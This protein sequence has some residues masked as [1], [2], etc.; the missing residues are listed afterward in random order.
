[1]QAPE[2]PRRE[3]VEERHGVEL[4]DPYRWLEAD[5]DDAPAVADWTARQN[6]YAAAVLDTPE[7]VAIEPRFAE[8]ARV[9]EYGPLSLAGGRSFQ[10][11]T[12]PDDEQAALYVRDGPDGDR[13]L[14]V[15]PGG[16]RGVVSLDWFVPSPDG[17]RAAYGVAEGGDEQYDVRVVD[18]DDGAVAEA[19]PDAGRLYADGLA[20]DADG[21]GFYY[22]T[23]GADGGDQLDK[24]VRYHA[25]GSDHRDD[26]LVAG[27]FGRQVWPGLETEGDVLVVEYQE[28]WDRS[29]VRAL[30]ADPGSATA[31]ELSLS[32]VVVDVDATVH[33]HLS[34]DR[35]FLVTDHGAP[36]SRVLACSVEEALD[37]PLALD[38]LD[39]PV[40][41]RE[42]VLRDVAVADDRL[43]AHYHDDAHSRVVSLDVADGDEE[44]DGTGDDR[45]AGG[46]DDRARSAAGPPAEVELDVPPYASVEALRADDGA[47]VCTVESFERPTRVCRADPR[48]GEVATIDEP[49]VPV[50]LDLVVDQEWFES[51]D[52]TSVPAFVVR[53]A[54]VERDGDR[55]TVLAGYGGFRVNSTPGFD[56]FRAPF[57]AAGGVYVLATLRG[58]AEFGEAWHDAGRREHKQRVFDDAVAVAEGLIDRGYTRPARLGIAGGSNGGLLVATLLT[59]R[60]ALFGAALCRV[61]LTDMLRFH[62]FLLGE[63]WTTEYGNP[64]DPA[65][66]EYLRAYSPYHNVEAAAYPPTLVTTA[67]GDTRVHPSHARKFVARLQ[68]ATTGS[69]PVVLRTREETG[70]GVGKPTSML[71]EENAEEWGFLAHHLGVELDPRDRTAAT[72]DGGV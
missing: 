63:A 16:N 53:R 52:G 2:T 26:P 40:P 54:D 31:P 46:D 69:S 36:N 19:V 21:A 51:A 32:P 12:F 64:D 5:A 41:E 49:D 71:V 70:H 3:T 25:L 55:P 27:D 66:F 29:A 33:P 50:D 38:A 15:D 34:G 48:T 37:G 72:R 20:W 44:G 45:P 68:A 65:D 24:A 9:T 1:M 47:V 14:L 42:A 4:V 35:L 61:P 59:Q 7:R 10:R 23:T 62:R 6:D 57:L 67:T 39:C 58:G 8:L 43:V 13:R 28:G 30:R 11:V 18:V 56:R 60:P 22:V 17:D